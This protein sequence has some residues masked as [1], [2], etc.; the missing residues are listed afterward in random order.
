MNLLCVYF[1]P[2]LNNRRA[3]LIVLRC[4]IYIGAPDY[5]HRRAGYIALR[6]LDVDFDINKYY[7]LLTEFKNNN[8]STCLFLPHIFA[9]WLEL[10]VLQHFD[11]FSSAEIAYSFLGIYL[12][13]TGM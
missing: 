4:I 1:A 9:V 2:R 11:A 6:C 13:K 10:L 8:A 7:K 5:I 12:S 3:L